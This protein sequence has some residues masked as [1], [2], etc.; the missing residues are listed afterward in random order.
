MATTP[1]GAYRTPPTGRLTVIRPLTR[2]FIPATPPQTAARPRGPEPS[3]L[4][5][6]SGLLNPATNA[7]RCRASPW[8]WHGRAESGLSSPIRHGG[9]GGWHRSDVA[10]GTSSPVSDGPEPR[11]DATRA[12]KTGCAEG[13]TWATPRTGDQGQLRPVANR[14]IMLVRLSTVSKCSSKRPESPNCWT[15][16]TSVATPNSSSESR[17][18]P[19]SRPHLIQ[20]LR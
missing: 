5:H 17:W 18:S 7:R 3:R 11:P 9:S 14:G 16:G 1:L 13:V 10:H 4:L 6:G 2:K 12:R 8:H 20:I 15:S 19:P